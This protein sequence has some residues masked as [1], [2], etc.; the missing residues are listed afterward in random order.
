MVK[1]NLNTFYF[2]TITKD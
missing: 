2:F 1:M